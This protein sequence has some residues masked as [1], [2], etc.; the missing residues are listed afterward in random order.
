MARRA[1]NC[2]F[3]KPI[4][5]RR[6]YIIGEMPFKL[7]NGSEML[8]ARR[9]PGLHDLVFRAHERREVVPLYLFLNSF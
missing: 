5:Q 1:S 6:Q 4:Q 8:L 2:V 9:T 3:R 7:L